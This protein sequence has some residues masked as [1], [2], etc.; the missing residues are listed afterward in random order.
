M[1]FQLRTLDCSRPK[2]VA[3]HQERLSRLQHQFDSVDKRIFRVEHGIEKL[4]NLS[5]AALKMHRDGLREDL[6][7]LRGGLQQERALSL[8]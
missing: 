3:R 5:L 8:V 6:A 4:E 1:A 7:R 2:S